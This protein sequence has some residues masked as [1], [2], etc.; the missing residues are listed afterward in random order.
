MLYNKYGKELVDTGFGEFD[1]GTCA[2]V[3]RDP[4]NLLLK[5]YK[6]DVNPRS[7]LTKSMFNILK[8]VDDKSFV[9][10]R[11]YYFYYYPNFMYSDLDAYTMDMVP[12]DRKN[13]LNLLYADLNYLYECS[14]ELERLAE[15]LSKLKIF[16]FDTNGYNIIFNEHGAVII[17]P[18]KFYRV[19][20]LPY[21][22]V[23]RQ[24]KEAIL[25]Y[26][27]SYI[28]RC[29]RESGYGYQLKYAMTDPLLYNKD[30]KSE[31]PILLRDLY[32]G[33]DTIYE[34]GKKR[35]RNRF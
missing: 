28:Y 16:L 4:N 1:N 10:L 11:D 6:W 5:V 27:R 35:V 25:E 23:L 15:K 20:F 9:K 29:A 3:Y 24:N 21:R 32:H 34:F 8:D 12:F 31:L 17:D 18:D 26:I 33:S 13:I 14:Y 19:P 2:N 22:M 7:H 30:L